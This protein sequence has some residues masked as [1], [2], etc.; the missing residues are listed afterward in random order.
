MGFTSHLNIAL[1]GVHWHYSGRR[2]LGTKL[3]F[4]VD[5]YVF[6]NFCLH[7]SA[8]REGSLPLL[9]LVEILMPRAPSGTLILP[10]KHIE[11]APCYRH[12]RGSSSGLH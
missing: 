6:C 3:L 2:K 1:A 12:V 11:C 9:G 7:R 8:Q 5:L 10:S 4:P